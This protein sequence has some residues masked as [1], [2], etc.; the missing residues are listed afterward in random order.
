MIVTVAKENT[1]ELEELEVEGS[2]DVNGFVS[3][4]AVIALELEELSPKVV[5]AKVVTEDSWE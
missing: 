2:E 4:E 5:E 3:E 1:D